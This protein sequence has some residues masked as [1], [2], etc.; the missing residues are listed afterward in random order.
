ML[1]C[2]AGLVIII[3]FCKETKDMTFEE[4]EALFENNV[5]I[6][7]NDDSMEASNN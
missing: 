6:P 5:I 7:F 1:C 2:I 4:I 3:L